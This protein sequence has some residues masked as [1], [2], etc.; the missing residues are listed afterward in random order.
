[1]SSGGGG[2]LSD[3]VDA[4]VL[5]LVLVGLA[6]GIHHWSFVPLA[7]EAVLLEVALFL[8][9][10]AGSVRVS[11]GGGGAG[12]VVA[13]GAVAVVVPVLGVADDSKLSQ[14]VVGQIVPN[15][16]L[17]SFFFQ[18]LLDG[19]DALEPFMI[20]LDGLQVACDLDALGESV[21]GSLKYLVA[22]SIL[23]TGQEEL[24]LYKLK[25]IRDTFGFDVSRGGSTSGSDNS[26]SSRLLVCETLVGHLY[27]VCVVV[28]G[29]LRFLVQIGE[30]SAGHLCRI[31][32]FIGF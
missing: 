21:L 4:V 26:H 29:L 27:A 2:L 30:V 23:E 16:L 22:D 10:P 3:I 17:S 18:L 15:D 25:S 32:W 9:V 11:H 12:L 14:L 19:V 31:F 6:I 13:A 8:A 20:N 1:M 5:V 28:D 24:M 7:G